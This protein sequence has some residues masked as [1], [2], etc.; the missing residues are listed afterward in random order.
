MAILPRIAHKYNRAVSNR[1][2][3]EKKNQNKKYSAWATGRNFLWISNMN[4]DLNSQFSLSAI[5]HLHPDNT[6]NNVHDFRMALFQFSA[7]S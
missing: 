7:N 6:Y 5:C 3:R 1:L 4:D 2:G